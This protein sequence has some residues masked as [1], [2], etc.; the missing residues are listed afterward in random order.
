MDKNAG[1][2]ADSGEDSGSSHSYPFTLPGIPKAN[3]YFL[4]SA[5]S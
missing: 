1:D 5:T 3:L 2:G 4:L